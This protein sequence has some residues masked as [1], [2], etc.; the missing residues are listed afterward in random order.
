MSSMHVF[1]NVV[2]VLEFLAEEFR[3]PNVPNALDA[4]VCL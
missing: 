4:L 1:A 2:I 3:L